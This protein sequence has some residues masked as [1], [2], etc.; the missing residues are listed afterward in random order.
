VRRM[1]VMVKNDFIRVGLTVALALALA[2]SLWALAGPQ[3]KAAQ[4]QTTADTECESTQASPLTGTFENVVVPNG[5]EC[6]LSN[7]EVSGDV[8]VLE[9]AT[10]NAFTNTIGG[11]VLGDKAFVIRLRDSTNVGGNVQAT[12]VGLLALYGSPRSNTVGGSILAQEGVNFNACGTTLPTGSIQ[13]MKS[14]NSNNV[15][16]GG[17]FCFEPALGGGGNK[18]L[19][20]SIQV[21]EN[22]LIG[23]G[24]NFSLDV[25]NNEVAQ[26]LQV[27]NNTGLSWK[28]VQNN[29]VGGNLQCTNNKPGR[30][31]GQPN[32]VVGSAEGQCA[33][34]S[35]G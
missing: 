7:S 17:D 2:A 15:H 10:L 11:N 29:T 20:G 19:E 30:F 12:A 4:A 33:T 28:R 13:V 14:Q 35:Q 32:D 18:L 1:T 3:T 24:Q 21:S 22:T 34:R 23:S 25:S 26:D 5:K 31:V 8:K 27:L 16:I 9:N 6:W